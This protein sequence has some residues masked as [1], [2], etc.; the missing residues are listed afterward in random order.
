MSAQA[1]GCAGSPAASGAPGSV[2]GLSGLEGA[3][4]DP[5]TPP[6][7]TWRPV[8]VRAAPGEGA[9]LH[10]LCT[11]R[12]ITVVDPIQRQL[13]DLA[14]VR[15]PGGSEDERADFL[16]DVVRR[17]GGL[18]AFGLWVYVPWERRIT[19]LLGP[20]D[21]FE[22]VTN[23]NRDKLTLQEQATLRTRRVGVVG[24]SVGGEAAVTLAQEH[25]CG[26]M[27]L[28]DFDALD[29]SNLN[30]L[31]A[32]F[33]DLG[34]N[35]A[36]IIARRIA[37]LDPYL[38]LTVLPE[39]VTEANVD[40]FLEGLDLLVEECDG[41]AMKHAIRVKARERGLNIV[42]AGDERGFLSVEPHGLRPD[43]PPVHGRVTAAQRPRESYADA[44]EFWKELTV[45]LGG[46]EE[47]S[48]RSR[49]SLLQ[50][51]T[52]LCGYPQLASEARYA[53]GQLGHVAR[54][55][56]LGERLAPFVGHVDLDE[57]LPSDDA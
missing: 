42:F 2:L 9:A 57:I 21:Y 5:S 34:R 40:A 16:A 14:S 44:R 39:G 25:L 29:L 18:D 4:D 47:I 37:K 13:D 6:D 52:T 12:H 17:A 31:G 15:L 36:V 46:W 43:L 11:P 54:R 45:W 53:A 56:L 33:D 8:L 51:G 49:A 24:L 19:H 55:L 3:L 35:K 28:A 50:I 41:L 23:R 32:G 48:E 20:D 1:K 26:E 38:K 10:A 7:T 22:V 30:R 27:A